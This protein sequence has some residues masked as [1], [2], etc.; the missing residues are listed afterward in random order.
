MCVHTSCSATFAIW[1]VV[2][3]FISRGVSVFPL[4]FLVNQMTHKKRM[5][6]GKGP[7]LPLKN[8][9]MM[10]AA[11]TLQY[12]ILIAHRCSVDP[13]RPVDPCRAALVCWGAM[14]GLRGAV[15]LALVMK[16]PSSSADEFS[17]TTLFV[18]MVSNVCLG[19]LTQP[20]INALGIPNEHSKTLR[21]SDKEFDQQEESS[22]L[23][24]A[25]FENQYL[26]FLVGDNVGRQKILQIKA[27]REK[28]ERNAL[29]TDQAHTA[30][31]SKPSPLNVPGSDVS[32]LPY[33]T[34]RYCTRKPPYGT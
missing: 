34:L 5:A 22:V 11:V 17:S 16:M 6:H 24:F 19:G 26:T 25:K 31:T 29:H 23:A 30:G 32:T 15:A 13:W 10:F 28:A 21:K 14:Q 9:I 1:A 4:A 12:Q 8:Q 18:I 27:Q 7:L 2:L 33:P 20:L 3:V